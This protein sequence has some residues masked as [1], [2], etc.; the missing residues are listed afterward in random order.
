MQVG[1]KCP[2]E[3]EI[4]LGNQRRLHERVY[5][6]RSHKDELDLSQNWREKK[7]KGGREEHIQSKEMGKTWMQWQFG[8]L[9]TN[10]R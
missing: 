6:T 7:K 9:L 5:Q 4:Y 2:A 3:C 10:D 1:T 8:K